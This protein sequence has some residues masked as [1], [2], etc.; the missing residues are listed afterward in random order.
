VLVTGQSSDRPIT[1][2]A[3]S[4]NGEYGLAINKQ[5]GA[6]VTAVT[7]SGD[8][9]GG[10]EV[11]RSSDV[12]VTDFTAT[13]QRIGVFTHVASGG[14]VLDRVRTTGGR[15]GVV[16]EKTTQDLHITDSTFQGAAVAGVSIGGQQTTLTGVQVRDSQT[17]VRIER[18]ADDTQLTNLALSG[19]RDGVV[20]KSGTTGTVITGLV[21]DNVA[22][23]A[24][25]TAA[26]GTRIVGG[27]IT[28]G[29][30]GIDA[31][32]ATTIT[33]TV[34]NAAESGIRSSSPDLVQA[35]GVTI[36]TLDV[37]IN[38]AEGGPFVLADSQ[39][40]ALESVRG[41]VNYQGI[42][43]LSLPPLNVI[44][45][46]GL[47]L[48]LVAFVLEQIHSARQRRYRREQGDGQARRRTPTVQIGAT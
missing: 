37:G 33:D 5:A 23:D 39:V 1:G 26:P 30:T 16:I 3:T 24:I 20:A 9:A 13:D 17:A 7:T 41:E 43:D 46:I 34:I 42:N 44:S 28:G 2:I 14:I 10:L 19:G 47:P 36:E 21:A 12:T 32:A 4:G 38:A 22:S 40:H 8:R 27:Q 25:R 35:I 15:W 45:V 18:G 29:T 6:R 31:E 48:V 11:S